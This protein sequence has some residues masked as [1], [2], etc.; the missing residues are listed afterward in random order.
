MVI[1]NAR[2]I[3][4]YW[5]CSRGCSRGFYCDC[6]FLFAFFSFF[7]S[8]FASLT[9]SASIFSFLAFFDFDGVAAGSLPAS[10]SSALAPA[11][12][13]YRDVSLDTSDRFNHLQRPCQ[14]PYGLLSLAFFTC[15]EWCCTL[16]SVIIKH[17]SKMMLRMS[18]S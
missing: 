17:E 10:S 11:G 14:L 18:R 8:F 4:T 7:T 6:L 5:R 16:C 12:R 1:S 2:I 15:N 9:G 13:L 3:V